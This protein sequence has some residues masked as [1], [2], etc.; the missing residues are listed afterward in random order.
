MVENLLKKAL[1]FQAEVLATASEKVKEVADSYVEKGTL[2]DAEA[3]KF[4]ED[5]K[6]KLS[7]TEKDLQEK[8]EKFNK[9]FQD[10]SFSLKQGVNPA[11]P[12]EIDDKI[13]KLEKELEELKIKKELAEKDK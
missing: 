1:L 4:V 13:E 12:Q 11:S 6:E 8:L 9:V 10:M 5:V 2:H 3:K 7:N